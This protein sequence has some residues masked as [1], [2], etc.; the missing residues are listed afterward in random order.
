MENPNYFAIIPAFIR[1]N[2]N[3]TMFEKILYWEITALTNKE[4]FCFAS[5]SYFSNLYKMH[6]VSISR[7]INNL[8]KNWFIK[9]EID[10][11]WWNQRKIFVNTNQDPINKNV[12]TYWQKNQ[13]PINKN[14]KHNNINI[15]NKKNN[16]KSKD[17]LLQKKEILNF[18]DLSEEKQKEI[19]NF[20]DLE[21]EL[22]NFNFLNIF[23]TKI[24]Q[25]KEYIAKINKKY[26]ISLENFK[27]NTR[28][29][30]LYRV[31]KND[32]WRKEKREK[33]NTFQIK[34]RLN[35]RLNN[36]KERQNYYPKKQ[37]KEFLIL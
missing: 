10:E 12:D 14:V 33:Q 22:E 30:I 11:K 15:I 2:E 31:E 16:N 21:W 19:L 26:N 1:Y 32:G 20:F 4:W 17:L 29:F 7:A 37:E 35:T 13:D 18:F 5:N 3:L 25:D 27:K 28:A 34:S 24:L 6:T 36:W 23:Y 8:E 9:I